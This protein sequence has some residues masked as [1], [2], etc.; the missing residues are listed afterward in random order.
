MEAGTGKIPCYNEAG[1]FVE[2]MDIHYDKSDAVFLA[3]NDKASLFSSEGKLLRNFESSMISYLPG[4]FV[5]GIEK[6]MTGVYLGWEANGYK[7]T[8]KY[9][10]INKLRHYLSLYTFIGKELINSA[11]KISFDEEGSCIYTKTVDNIE[12]EGGFSQKDHSQQI[13]C[14]F[15][16]IRF[17]NN[18]WNIQRNSNS[19]EEILRTCNEQ[20]SLIESGQI[21]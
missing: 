13:P 21:Y 19:Q 12:K 8:S 15:H 7:Y 1:N 6:Q 5:V 10:T 20:I 16:K 2:Y 3:K 18:E 9:L 17:H 11:E 4:Y 14:L